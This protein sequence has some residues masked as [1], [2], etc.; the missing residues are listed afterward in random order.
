M[1]AERS[2]RK[3]TIHERLRILLD[4]MPLAC[5]LWK[6]DGTVFE[7]NEEN[8]RLFQVQ[9]K[10]NFQERF[11]DFSP[12]YQPDG[13]R[14]DKKAAMYLEKAFTDGRC[15]FQWMHQ[16]LDGTPIPAEIT[17]VRVAYAND[18][19]VAGYVRDLREYHRMLD[20]IGQRDMLLRAVNDTAAILLSHEENT[21][22]ATLRK[23][24]A[25]MAG[26]MQVDNAYI[27]KNETIGGALYYVNLHAWQK[28]D[29]RQE[30][31]IRPAMQYPYSDS[32]RWESLFRR[33]ECINSPVAGLPPD[34]QAMLLPF[35]IKS[36][37]AIPVHVQGELW[38]FISFD[39]CREERVFTEDEVHILRSASY[40]IV[41]AMSQYRMTLEL[42]ETAA[43]LQKALLAAQDAS[44][45]K[46]SFLATMSH[47][48]RTPMNAI[49][50]MTRIGKSASD[51]EKMM[52]AFDRI[53]GASR[54]LLGV[55]NDILDMSKIE[56][57]KFE[58]S[59]DAFAFEKMILT[60]VNIISFRTEEKRQKLTVF[61]DKNIPHALVGDDQRL[62]QVITNLLSNAVKFTPEEN[63][64]RLEAHLIAEQDTT[65]TVKIS[66]TD[67][68]I[69]ISAEQQARLFSS[70]QQAESSISRQFG[71]T[72][73]G[74][75]I[76]K[77]LVGLMG[78]RIWVESDLG[79]GATFSFTIQAGR[80]SE[81][82]AASL[83]PD[84][85]PTAIRLLVVDGDR[86]SLDCFLYIA[87]Q[88]GVQCDAVA[89][90]AEALRRIDAGASYAI[91][92][93]AYMMHDMNGIALSRH[94]LAHGEKKPGIV[95]V[96]A[97]D[98]GNI[99]RDAREA[100]VTRFLAKPLLASTVAD[101]ISKCLAPTAP[102]AKGPA[103]ETVSL[104]GCRLLLV[105]DIEINREIVLAMLE[106]TLIIIDCAENGAEAVDMFKKNCNR[107][108]IIFMDVQMPEMDGYEA[109]RRIRAFDA[110]KAETIPIIAM[111]ANVFRE[112]KEKCLAAG[113]T[114]H[115]GKPL[116]TSEVLRVLQEHLR[117]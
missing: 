56:A 9:D 58:L 101:C 100:G 114:G 20:A 38:G 22:E 65:C 48:I 39:D 98:W 84:I 74:L 116:D 25:H 30:P 97:Y 19:V 76:S 115:M 93:I 28:N 59:H 69:G 111:T 44:N 15:V 73:L 78:G 23:G 24:I 57:G 26:R 10:H 27:W 63:S 8:S 32:P 31:V 45:A 47:E 33:G 102:A 11:A 103:D 35:R 75:A 12:E 41:N 60:V 99:E 64:I 109:T 36:I 13:Q 14:S 85:D 81:Y 113:M 1:T 21:F 88:L 106:P 43:Q 79:A 29:D 112:D 6:E 94:I 72:G 62:S 95:M 3:N 82:S 34:E 40:M 68:G 16:A 91:C 2:Q 90:G 71:G 110:A 5:H 83:L 105:D 67:T 107:Y 80:A 18:Y 86:E 61:I 50:G 17:L 77:H 92:F 42:Q 49:I 51:M 96:S 7:A 52:Y 46:S 104:R 117:R 108:D 54:H 37:L 70:F 89:C 87:E 55:I 4:A 53:G 66:V